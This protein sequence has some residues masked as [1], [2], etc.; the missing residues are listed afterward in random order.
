MK[1]INTYLF[2]IFSLFFSY[3]I[4]SQKLWN[5][6]QKLE[7]VPN[8]KQVYQKDNFPEAYQIVQFDID[9]FK[10]KRYNKL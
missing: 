3:S 1:S 2:F 5:A 9:F 8:S 7:Y 6:L 10:K 4:Q